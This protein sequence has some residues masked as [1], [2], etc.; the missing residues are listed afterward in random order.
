MA[1][2]YTYAE[3]LTPDH[4]QWE[5]HRRGFGC[6]PEPGRALGEVVE[7]SG[8]RYE[9]TIPFDGS[10]RETARICAEVSGDPEMARVA[11]LTEVTI[12]L[13]HLRGLD[14]DTRIVVGFG[15]GDYT[16]AEQ[17]RLPR[18]EG[19]MDPARNFEGFR[20]PGTG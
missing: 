9:E 13:E 18:Y 20:T 7:R 17:E 1:R 15:I 6:G 14:P 12:P 8:G 2:F 11:G 10:I 16:E 4:I 5:A 19:P 3:V